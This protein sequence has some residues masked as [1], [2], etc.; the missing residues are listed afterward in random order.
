MVDAD[1]C[2]VKEEIVEIANSFTVD[3]VFVA[4]YAHMQ[5]DLNGLSGNLLTAVRKLQIYS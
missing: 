3:A 4:S 5:N 1:S 2:P